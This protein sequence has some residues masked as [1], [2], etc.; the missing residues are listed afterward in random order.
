MP[1]R[2]NRAV[3]G[4][5]LLSVAPLSRSWSPRSLFAVASGNAEAI[6]LARASQGE[7]S[8]PAKNLLSFPTVNALSL[9]EGGSKLYDVVPRG[10]GGEQVS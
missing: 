4:F 6:P 3:R 5:C 2:V 9:P 8:R 7:A 1:G 10:L